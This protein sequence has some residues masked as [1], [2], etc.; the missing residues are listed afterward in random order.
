MEGREAY[1]LFLNPTLDDL[2]RLGDE[3]D[4]AG[5]VDDLKSVRITSLISVAR[6]ESEARGWRE[7]VAYAIVLDGLSVP[8][9]TNRSAGYDLK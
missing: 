2:H 4:G 1:S 6:I 5:G 7:G 9:V 8:M 3:G